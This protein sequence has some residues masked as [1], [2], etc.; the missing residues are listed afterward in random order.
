MSSR[1]GRFALATVVMSL[2]LGG[3][4]GGPPDLVLREPSVD[5]GEVSNGQVKTIEVGVENAGRSDLVIEAISTSCGCTTAS[6]EPMTIGPGQSG[7]LT[8]EYDS[9][10]HGPDF[11]GT[12]MRQVFIDSND[13]DQ[14]EVEFRFTAD[15]VSP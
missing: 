15:V 10:A 7:K 12:V 2:L 13:P 9:G 3:C 1:A 14:P 8:V 4:S 6:I 11:T 5:L